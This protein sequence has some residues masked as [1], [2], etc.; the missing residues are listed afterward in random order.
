MRLHSLSLVNYIGVYNGMGLDIIDIDFSKCKNNIVVIKGDNGSGKST[1][2]KA[3]TPMGDNSDDL[4]PGKPAQKSIS[5]RTDDG[6]IIK[7]IYTYPINKK[8]ERGQTKCNIFKVMGDTTVDLNPN[9]NIGEAKDMIDTLFDFDQNFVSLSQLSSED[10]GLADKK[11]SER[12]KFINSIIESMS[13]YNVMYKKLVKK[14]SALKMNMVSINT[15]IGSIGNKEVITN[16]LKILE[17]TLGDLEDRRNMLLATMGALKARSEQINSED[18]ISA[19]RELKGKLFQYER[20]FSE[21]RYDHN[22]KYDQLDDVIRENELSLQKIIT[23]KAV[24]EERYQN[25]RLSLTDINKSIQQKENE[26]SY[27][28]STESYEQVQDA[29]KE[30]QKEL[31]TANAWMKSNNVSIEISEQDYESANV[32]IES[33]NK[34]LLSLQ[35]ND[36]KYA[37]IQYVMD[38]QYKISSH[39]EIDNTLID[40]NDELNNLYTK[41]G[42]LSSESVFSDM[43]IPKACKLKDICPLAIAYTK[44]SNTIA[45]HNKVSAKIE[46]VREEIQ[47]WNKMKKER[48]DFDAASKSV[49][50]II[51]SLKSNS[52]LLSKFGIKFKNNTQISSLIESTDH[53]DL[54]LSIFRNSMNYKRL[55]ASN[56]MRLE[57]L[58]SKE[59]KLKQ[60]KDKIDGLKSELSKMM[61]Q[62]DKLN[63]QLS[64]ISVQISE[65]QSMYDKYNSIISKSKHQKEVYEHW[66]KKEEYEKELDKL[67]NTYKEAQEINEKLGS[68]KSELDD[69][70]GTKYTSVTEEMETLKHRLVLYN[71]YVEEYKQFSEK[72]EVIEKVKKYTSPTTGIQTVFMGMYMNDII[73]TSNQL[74]SLMFGGE[75]VLHPFVINENEFRIPCSGRGL[76]NDDI[77]S[78]STS[79]ICMISMIIS[80]ALLHKASSVYNIIKLDEMDGGLDTQNRVNFIILLQKM[81]S[82]LHV[83]QCIMISHNS[84]LSMQNADIIMLRNSDPNLKIDGNVIFKL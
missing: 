53:L 61:D 71:E 32:L 38:K 82:L 36:M 6:A 66:M 77:S 5:Y 3:L 11:P 57:E 79:Q 31:D 70:T 34:E 13:E 10:R 58:R 17:D 20:Y 30:A 2:F 1:I 46:I 39:T 15:K 48:F 16:R 81:M 47:K 9:G 52:N 4:I 21:N 73:N 7:I 26:L 40:L 72:Y 50:F 62:K 80:F 76:L 37:A 12:K 84:E 65:D 51:D 35:N 64:K 75:Y 83:E 25:T 42:G 68:I 45:D 14:S 59:I 69:V 78:M 22:I 24:L 23:H 8:G 19:T 33:I 67:S 18:I 43:G 49:V 63:D 28:S 44:Q 60:N 27:Y 29:I 74:L 56:S 55:I 41:L 54:D